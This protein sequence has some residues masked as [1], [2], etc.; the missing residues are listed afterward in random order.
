MSPEQIAALTAIA[1]IVSKIGTWPI[2]SILIV[3]SLAP[4]IVMIFLHWAQEKRFKA[5]IRMY[6]SNVK[7]VVSYEKLANEN[8]DTIRLSTA[9]VV[10][11]TT[12]LKTRAPCH[13]FISTNLIAHLA[14]RRTKDEPAK[15]NAEN[16]EG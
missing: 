10:D 9:A 13:Q 16:T 5:V 6:E 15:R 1:A 14:E 2:G 12:Y 4:W 8:A 11:L 3:W 7:L